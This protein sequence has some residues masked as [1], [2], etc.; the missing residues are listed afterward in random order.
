MFTGIVSTVARVVEIRGTRIGVD[1]AWIAKHLK[2]G[3]SVAVNGVCL[4]VVKKQGPVFFADVVPET[5][6]RTNLGALKVGSG[7]NLE[8]PLKAESTID[9][10]LVQGHVDTTAA[11]RSV[12]AVSI[13]KE[14]TIEL[15]ASIS[16]FVAEK[17]SIAVDGVSLT[18]AGVDKATF[19]VA[20]I[21]HTLEMTIARD[22]RRGSVV[23]LEADVIARYVARNLRR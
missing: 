2:V 3:G 8:L 17:G 23:N 21:P 19:T 11:V 18:V 1:H 10:H 20:L 22:Y 16:R 7:V 15:P 4:T 9:G 13:G 12:R 5:R 14:I 6:K